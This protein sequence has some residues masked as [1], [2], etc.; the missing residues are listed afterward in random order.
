MV[1][2]LGMGDGRGGGGGHPPCK[3]DRGGCKHVQGAALM[4]LVLTKKHKIGGPAFRD[5]ESV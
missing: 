5:S 2:V 4:Y 1:C 3:I